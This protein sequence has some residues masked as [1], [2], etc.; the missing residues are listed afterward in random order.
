[1]SQSRRFF[2][3]TTG[4]GAITTGLFAGAA[5]AS[6]DADNQSDQR[7]PHIPAA[8]DNKNI[9]NSEFTPSDVRL[10]WAFTE[11]SDWVFSSPTIVNNTVY[12][13]SNDSNLYAI[14]ADFGRSRP[15]S[16]S[17]LSRMAHSL[18]SIFPTEHL[19]L[20][21]SS[22]IKWQVCS[23]AASV[24][25]LADQLKQISIAQLTIAPITDRL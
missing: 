22:Q 13:G 25:P 12:V 1:M 10:D 15:A 20:D 5:S 3:K 6:E 21:D 16:N 17:I 18:N 14:N 9:R 11:P 24:T 8:A 4:A 2:L 19:L 23:V 7:G